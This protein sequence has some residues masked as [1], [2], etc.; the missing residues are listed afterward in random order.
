MIKIKLHCRLSARFNEDRSLEWSKEAEASVAASA[1][2]V[3][4]FIEASLNYASARAIR[5]TTLAWR[6]SPCSCT[7]ERE[8]FLSHY[9]Y[10]EQRTPAWLY[11]T[12]IFLSQQVNGFCIA[13]ERGIRACRELT[14]SVPNKTSWIDDRG[15][16]KDKVEQTFLSLKFAS[17]SDVS[18]KPFFVLSMMWTCLKTWFDLSHLSWHN[19][20]PC[21][22]CGF[23]PV[24]RQQ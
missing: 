21:S 12:P 24:N 17:K 4:S 11:E 22:P 16:G 6:A 23:H 20:L 10:N 7:I 15:N 14:L 3:T 9:S 18:K 8:C 19:H 13:L 1:A 2:A 5:E